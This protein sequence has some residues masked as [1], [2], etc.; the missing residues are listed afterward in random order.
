MHSDGKWKSIASLPRSLNPS[1]VH[2]KGLLS[3]PAGKPLSLAL[4]SWLV[5]VGRGVARAAQCRMAATWTHP[6]AIGTME[7]GAGGGMEAVFMLSCQPPLGSS[8]TNQMT[9]ACLVLS[10]LW[11]DKSSTI[12][13]TKYIST[14]EITR[15][16][17][18]LCNLQSISRPPVHVHCPCRNQSCSSTRESRI[19]LPC[20]ADDIRQLFLLYSLLGANG[21]CLYGWFVSHRVLDHRDSCQVKQKIKH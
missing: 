17:V 16:L 15:I 14:N 4:Q 9:A 10:S 21:M 6:A 3:T 18:L 7:T 1:P 13:S 12:H 8:D 11:R 5:W 2:G 20:D 19:H